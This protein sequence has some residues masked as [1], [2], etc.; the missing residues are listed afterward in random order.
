MKNWQQITF[1]FLVLLM[2]QSSFAQR[3][4]NMDPAERAKKQTEAMKE[5]LTLS[6][7]QASKVEA[8]LLA[9]SEKMMTAREEAD[10]DRS[11]MREAMKT[12][13]EEKMD[14]MKKYLTAEQF[15]AYEKMEQ[16]ALERRQERMNGKKGKGKKQREDKS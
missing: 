12:I 15:T 11:A 16:E 4:M 9:T 3:G 2:G 14:E 1:L 6:D 8:V 13:Q 10:G 7:A 5:Q